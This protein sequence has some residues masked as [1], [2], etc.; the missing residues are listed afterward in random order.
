MIAAKIDA[1]RADSWD[2]PEPPE[3]RVHAAPAQPEEEPRTSKT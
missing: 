3:T 1:P 2:P